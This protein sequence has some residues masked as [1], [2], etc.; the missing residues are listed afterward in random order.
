MWASVSI[1]TSAPHFFALMRPL[2]NKYLQCYH[3]VLCYQ[4][5]STKQAGHPSTP[6]SLKEN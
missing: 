2:H 3:K 4:D 5:S 6:T 1:K